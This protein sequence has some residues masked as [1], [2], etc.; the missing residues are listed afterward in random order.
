VHLAQ[1][2]PDMR[3]SSE[4]ARM[5]RSGETARARDWPHTYTRSMVLSAL[6]ALMRMSIVSD[7]NR[8]SSLVA[9][10]VRIDTT[11]S[12]CRRREYRSITAPSS[13]NGR[14]CLPTMRGWRMSRANSRPL[15]MK[16]ESP[17]ASRSVRVI[18]TLPVA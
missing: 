1:A 2:L 10:A 13:V 17:R 6:S 4:S 12:S 3:T 5:S 8:R 11:R 15:S 14:F 16:A 7:S 9:F 18:S